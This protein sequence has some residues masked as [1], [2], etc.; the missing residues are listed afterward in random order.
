M[1]VSAEARWFWRGDYPQE[2][3]DWFF[4]NGICKWPGKTAFAAPA[5]T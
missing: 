4:K 3:Q 2:L 1:F 5:K